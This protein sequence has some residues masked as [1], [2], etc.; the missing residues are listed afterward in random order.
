MAGSV[1]PSSFKFQNMRRTFNPQKLNHEP[2][3]INLKPAEP[4]DLLRFEL[5]IRFQ[6]FMNAP[7]LISW[8]LYTLFN[9]MY[10]KGL[11][12]KKMWLRTWYC[13]QVL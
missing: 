3:H 11:H 2:S 9:I 8:L 7:L 1:Y 12:Q 13:L 6:R 4:E 5:F 10:F